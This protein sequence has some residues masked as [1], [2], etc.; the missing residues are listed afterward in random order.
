MHPAY[1]APGSRNAGSDV[2]VSP[3]GP[4]SDPANPQAGVA[5][6]VPFKGPTLLPRV[7]AVLPANYNRVW[8]RAEDPA[9]DKPI[10]PAVTKA[11]V[12]EDNVVKPEEK[13]FKQKRKGAKGS[14]SSVKPKKEQAAR[15]IPKPATVSST[16]VEPTPTPSSQ[17]KNP[18]ARSQD[19]PLKPLAEPAT[20]KPIGQPSVDSN[21]RGKKRG[22]KKSRVVS[23]AASVIT[24]GNNMSVGGM[25]PSSPKKSI[26]ATH[27]PKKS[28]VFSP[29]T[30][31]VRDRTK[32]A[33]EGI[34]SGSP[35][36][37]TTATN[38]PRLGVFSAPSAGFPEGNKTVIGVI[39][40]TLFQRKTTRTNTT[41]SDQAAQA[42]SSTDG[43]SGSATA[44]ETSGIGSVL[45]TVPVVDT[46]SDHQEMRHRFD[47][48]LVTFYVYVSDITLEGT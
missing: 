36:K 39:D 25:D 29:P 1:E 21:A 4:S 5:I 10:V 14:S 9:L 41:V 33:I 48:T 6:P 43:K 20:A 34:N 37:N 24:E 35:K 26:R 7:L 3:K 46:P 32:P 22:R 12:A 27:P 19:P 44:E 31:D 47:K 23:S 45:E 40:S 28:G 30:S 11:I 8:K 16:S 2:P 38:A 13:V 17:E 42:P 18:A 15:N